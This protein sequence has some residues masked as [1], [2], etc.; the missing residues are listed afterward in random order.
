MRVAIVGSRGYPSRGEVVDYVGKL[1]EGFVVV[2]GGAEGVDSWAQE[3]ALKRGMEFTIHAVTDALR[4]A[5]GEKVAPLKRNELIVKDCE[6]LVAFWDMGSRGTLHAI[7]LALI[8]GK[9]LK[10]FT[11]FGV[12]RPAT[13]NDPV[14][15][16]KDDSIAD[17]NPINLGRIWMRLVDLEK[18]VNEMKA[19]VANGA[20]G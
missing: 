12:L 17:L 5:Y 3:A 13:P 2:S 20:V 7:R 1:P 4:Q 9:L 8:E 16:P 11:P 14:E 19:E 18:C 6:K 10:V 15:M